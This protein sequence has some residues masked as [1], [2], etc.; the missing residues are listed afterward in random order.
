[1]SG[2]SSASDRFTGLV[3]IALGQ[4]R[5]IHAM[6]QDVVVP[7][8]PPLRRGIAE[9][10]ARRVDRGRIFDQEM[11]HDLEALIVFIER[12]A[13]FGVH[14]GWKADACHIRGGWPTIWRDGRSTDLVRSCGELRGLRVAIAA[15]LDAVEAERVANRLS[16]GD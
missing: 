8:L 2:A 4:S 12:E 1:M 5:V 15:V 13:E 9:E 7:H 10:V 3:E 6:L 11:L 14:H 16:A